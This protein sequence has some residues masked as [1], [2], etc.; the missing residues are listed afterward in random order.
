MYDHLAL[1]YLLSFLHSCPFFDQ[2]QTGFIATMRMR[3]NP[4]LRKRRMVLYWL[5][6]D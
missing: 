3:G 4:Y 5:S 6:F 2:L 1:S